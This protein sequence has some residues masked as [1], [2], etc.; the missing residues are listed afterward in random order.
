MKTKILK[1]KSI[2]LISSLLLT[3]T[4]FT[5]T[6]TVTWLKG[7][8]DNSGGQ[9]R[10][11]VTDNSGNIFTT[12]YFGSTTVFGNYTL[13]AAGVFDAFVCKS[14][15][16]GNVL[17]VKQFGGNSDAYGFS[18]A[19]DQ[20][21]NV[22]VGG[23][24]L[25]T[26]VF[27]TTTL[28]TQIINGYICK[29]DG[30]GN[31]LWVKQLGVSNISRTGGICSDANGNVYATGSFSGSAIFGPTTLNSNGKEDGFITKLDGVGNTLWA[32]NFGGSGSDFGNDISSDQAGNTYVVGSFSTIA[33][34]GSYLSTSF[35]NSDGFVCQVDPNGLTLWVRQF[36]GSGADVCTSIE[37]KIPGVIHIVG[38][39][40]STAS[41][42][43]STLIAVGQQDVFVTKMN[44]SG[45]VLW[46]QRFGAMATTAPQPSEALGVC[47]DAIGNVYTTGDFKGTCSFG[48]T[49]L[50]A[51]VLVSSGAMSAPDAFISK[52]NPSGNFDFVKKLGGEADDRG[53]DITADNSGS[54]ICAGYY[55]YIASIDNFTLNEAGPFLVKISADMVLSLLENNQYSQ[56]GVFP[57]PSSNYFQISGLDRLK[58]IAYSLFDIN[59]KIVL[60]S[61]GEKLNEEGID[62]SFID[63]GI[64]FL[65]INTNKN[66]LVK[67]VI[68]N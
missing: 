12:G 42:G 3:I 31:V 19:T 48:S 38:N 65:K 2:L 57:N 27:G 47:T 55:N 52:L 29:L 45:T 33:T 23:D 60:K 39:F 8:N 46:A 21:G 41:I 67:K 13:T 63:K 10:G 34:F 36:G 43:T 20:S 5:Q 50:S 26:C 62:I 6:Q 18:I 49:T 11:V 37:S 4:T 66:C 16:S 44:T 17:W 64:Y 51:A 7:Y 1:Q 54:I 35:G 28:T 61:E 9:G 40:K 59:G 53:R 25:N 14:D 30:S 24:F 32:K 58:I 56:L 15:P 68:K 22:F